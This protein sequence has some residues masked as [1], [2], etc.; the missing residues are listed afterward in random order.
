MSLI[1]SVNAQSNT[2]LPVACSSIAKGLEVISTFKEVPTF[3]G[4]DEQHEIE[5]LNLVMF[6]NKETQTFTIALVSKEQNRFCA[7]SSGT[8]V[9]IPKTET[10]R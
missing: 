4:K 1:T 8:G 10:K 9:I 2:N 7:I 5:N 6:L 3:M